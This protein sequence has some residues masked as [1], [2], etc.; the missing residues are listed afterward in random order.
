MEAVLDRKTE[1]AVERLVEHYQTT[2]RH[3]EEQIRRRRRS[4]FDPPLG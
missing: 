3:I 4:G 2:L 1:L